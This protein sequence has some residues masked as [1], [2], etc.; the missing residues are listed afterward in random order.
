M[1]FTRLTQFLDSLSEIGI[2]GVD[3]RIFQD[4]HEIYRHSAGFRDREAGIP[5]SGDELYN[6][7]SVSKIFTCAAALTLYERGK[8]LMTDPVYEYLPAYRNL[9][10]RIGR[11][12]GEFIVRP[13]REAMTLRH[14]FTMCSGLSYDLTSPSILEAVKA[15]GGR[16][17]TVEIASAFA[18]EPLQFE[19]GTHWRY[20]LSHDVLAAVVEVISGK[21]F[22]QYVKENIFDP[23]GMTR[24]GYH[25]DAQ[26][27]ARMASQ[28]RFDAA[29]NN[30][31]QISKANP[32]KF[33][34]DY[35]SGGAGMI[36]Y[37]D[38]CMK[39]ADAMCSG[40][41]AATGERI[42]SSRTIDLM[43]TNHLGPEQMPDFDWI[44]FKGYGYGL[45][46]RTMVDPSMSGSPG[47][48]GE[49][50]WGGAAGAYMLIDPENHLCAYYAQH[51]LE[52]KEPYVHPRLR[53]ILYSCL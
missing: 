50:G 33:G 1:D 46:V 35:E 52:N 13:A 8:F 16:A 6:L 42:L 26:I 41:V 23:C 25:A 28:Y 29:L 12:N 4:R 2:P 14:L 31:V 7:Y 24:S 40:G 36:S 21:R 44:Q 48:M 49:F 19:P 10:V 15:T 22:S 51:M 3:M 11:G 30:S 43:R 9:N 39:F 37:V 27:E 5:I 20:S 45:G 17:P 32:Y 47:P 38:D 53:N 18:K 34:P